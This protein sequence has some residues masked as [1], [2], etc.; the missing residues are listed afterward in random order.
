M[1]HRIS[2]IVLVLLVAI[3]G[4]GIAFFGSPTGMA[5][6]K[7]SYLSSSLT[8]GQDV[9]MRAAE[10]CY[11]QKNRFDRYSVCCSAPCAEQ[12]KEAKAVDLSACQMVCQDSCVKIVTSVY[13]KRRPGFVGSTNMKH[14]RQDYTIYQS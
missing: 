8:V 4:V 5:L 7:T 1:D 9:A 2:G 14:D 11:P 6:G 13:L 10:I 12:C 3:I